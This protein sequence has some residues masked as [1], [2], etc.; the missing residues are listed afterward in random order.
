MK[1]HTILAASAALV[2]G[3][4]SAPLAGADPTPSPTPS[5]GYQDHPNP[6]SCAD[7]W[8]FHRCL[9]SHGKDMGEPP[10]YLQTHTASPAW[11]GEGR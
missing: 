9:E 6:T 11:T 3:L 8:D 2:V 5:G 4:L 10:W 7:A 1:K